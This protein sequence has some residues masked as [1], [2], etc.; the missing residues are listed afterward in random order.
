[1]T[2]LIITR[3]LP[4]SGKSTWAKA[5][6]AEDP[7]NRVRVN[8]D[9]LRFMMFG[10]YWG[11]GVDEDAVTVAEET[12]VKSA[13]SKGKSV[14]V[15][16][17]HLR[18]S[19]V[20]KWARIHPVVLKDFAIPVDVC[21]DNDVIR[22][23]EGGRRVGERVIRDMA[24]RYKV[25]SVY[26]SLPVVNLDDVQEV[27][28]KPYLAGTTPAYCF[29]ID[30]TLA[31]MVDRGPYDTSKYL[32]DVAD[33]HV[34]ELMWHLQDGAAYGVENYNWDKTLDPS[35]AFLILS[36]RD[37]EFK[38]VLVEWLRGWG[39][40][41]PEE[42]IFMRPKGDQRNDAIIKSELVDKHIS[43]V[44]DVI[45]H[46]DDRDRVVN[47]LRRKGMKVAQVEPGDF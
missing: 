4:A 9:D 20:R 28:M 35:V 38:P 15:D 6:V 2:E 26:G 12:L 21:I 36:G 1:M 3:G 14:V 7:A 16:A 43:G 29:D 34:S 23:A 27:E 10:K 8:R 46:F 40:E 42:N 45:M 22:S 39:L 24:R 32:T 25:D 30:G 33:R 44:Y 17:T 11:K 47:A 18:A 37:E 13:L 19:V 5:W 31:R 41:I